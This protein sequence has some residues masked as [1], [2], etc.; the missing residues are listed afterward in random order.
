MF[1]ILITM[2]YRSS[3]IAH[4]SVPEK[5]PTIDTLEQLL[6]ADRYTWGMEETYGIGWEWFKESTIPTVQKVNEQILPLTPKEHLTR[7]LKGHHAFL[8]WKYYIKAIIL[9]S[10]TDS[11]G[12][13]PLHTG[14]AEYINYGGYGW[15]FRKGAPFRRRIDKV[16]LRLIESGLI[17]YW[18]DDLI[19]TS[20]RK[21]RKNNLKKWTLPQV[22]E[23]NG[24]EVV[25]SLLHLQGTFYVL[26]LGF[27]L[28]FI[29]LIAE[30]LT[31]HMK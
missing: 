18:I 31:V 13:T 3:L 7:V 2:A 26:S 16:K 20:S 11:R 4:L 15:G 25:L 24:G 17:N 14:Q 10:Y 19:L 6:Q 23:G 29:V 1:S 5:S 12:Y 30:N 8:T 22:E 9:S 27:C 28:A 21:A